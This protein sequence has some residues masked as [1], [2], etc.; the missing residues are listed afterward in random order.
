M[1]M[2]TNIKTVGNILSGLG[3]SLSADFLARLGIEKYLDQLDHVVTLADGERQRLGELLRSAEHIASKQL[4]DEHSGQQR[5]HLKLGELLIEKAVLSR[6][7][8]EVVLE[9]Q[10]R[11]ERAVPVAGE[12]ALGNILVAAGEISR[13]QLESALFRQVNSGKR[14]GEE[15]IAAGAVSKRQID[16]GLILQLRL[17]AYALAV[18]VG[19]STL[20]TPA[21]AGQNSAAMPVSVTVVANAKML[22]HF[23]ATDLKITEADIALGYIEILSASRF[24]VK[25]NSRAGYLLEFQPVIDIFNSVQIAGLGSNVSLGAEGGTIVKRGSAAETLIQELSFRFTLR[26]N[27]KPG[28]YPW[29]LLLSVRAL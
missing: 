28:N 19:L 27:T 21:E 20:S 23:Q 8:K 13:S 6:R 16:G 29:P 9:F 17:A 7:E 18:T 3:V 1:E 26:Q 4:D 2:K 12:F 25:T 22:T 14:L 24:S 15:L 10:Q 5:D 11:R